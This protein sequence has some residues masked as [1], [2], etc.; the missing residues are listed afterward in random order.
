MEFGGIIG[1][2]VSFVAGG[3]LMTLVT[4]K[5]S[6]KKADVEVKVDEIKAIHDTVELVYKPMID[7]QNR[8]IKELE[9][10]VKSLRM[11]LISERKDHQRDIDLMNKR[12]LAITNAL[13][14]KANTQLRNDKG[15][16]IKAD[17][18]ES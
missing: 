8:R 18:N 16:F 10:E 11:Q 15:Q 9:D 13:G 5:S 4:L 14:I 6:K 3:G 7:Q 17:S 1:N 2:V 12:I